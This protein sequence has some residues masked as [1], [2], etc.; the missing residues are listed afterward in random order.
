MYV[1]LNG[2]FGIGKTTV[3]RELRSRLD[4][5][6]I[7]DPEHVGLILRRLPGY[8]HSDFQHSPTWRRAA[9]AGARCVGMVRSVVIVPMA[10]S[11]FA[12]L[13][14]VRD[15]LSSS[16]RPVLHFCLTAPVEVVQERLAA[17]GEPL[18]DPRWSWVHRRAAE[19]CAAHR[20]DRFAVQV[21]TEN[22]SPASIADLLAARV[23]AAA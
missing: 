4:S 5:A 23:R 18:E 3:A 17:R 2:A 12:Y 1:L 20:E 19:C 10:F 16:R 7:F 14:E 11:E 8:S 13:E 15:G 6:G 21:P 9:I 22:E